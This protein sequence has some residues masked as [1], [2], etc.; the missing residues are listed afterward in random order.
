MVSVQQLDQEL[1]SGVVS[2]DRGEQPDN[3][4]RIALL[5]AGDTAALLAFAA[6]GRQSHGE[7]L[8]LEV[9][10]TAA[11][12]VVGWFGAALAVG[13]YAKPAQRGG[14]PAAAAWTAAH[15]WALGVPAGLV[16][17]SLLRGYVPDATFLMV[18]MA[19]TGV[20]TIGWRATLAA[21][22]PAPK[23][24]Q[25]LREVL[26]ARKDR[27]GNPFEFLEMIVS[28]TRRW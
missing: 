20:L 22:T 8:G 10:A 23:E 7:G 18:S 1:V 5:A 6:I 12:F 19:A 24:P 13:G 25:T 26:D 15:V 27:R 17:R 28:M 2:V 11:P 14:D 4:G 9:L 3:F 16:L 21:A